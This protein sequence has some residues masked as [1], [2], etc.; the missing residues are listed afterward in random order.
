MADK[1]IRV[2]W[3][4]ELVDKTFL[5]ACIQELTSNGREGSGLKESSWAVVAEKLKTDH[6][7]IVDKKQMKNRYDYL[8]AKYAVWLKLK[9]KT[10]NIYNPVTNSFNMTNEEWEAEAKLNKY[11]D[12]L[13]NAPLPCPELCTQ[14]FDGATSTSVHSWGPSSTLPH[15]NETFSTHDFEDTEMDEPAPHADTPSST[16]PQPTSEESSGRTKNKG[17]KRN[18]P[19]ET[20]L[21]DELKEVGKEIIK[22]AQAFTEA[23]NLDK[24]MDA[25]MAKLTSLEWGEYDPKSTTAL[26]LFAESSGHNERFQAVKE[27]FHHPTQTIHQCFHE[28][29][30]AMM[31]FSREII[32][33][34]SSNSTRN[35][36][37][38]HRRLMQIFPG[39]IGA[40]DGTLVHAVVPVDQQTRYRGR[41]KVECYQ[42]VIGICNFDMIFTFVWAGCEGIA[43]DSKVL[44]EVAF[45]PTSGFPFPPPDKYYLCDAAYT[46]TRGFMAPYR[47]TRYWLADFQRNRALTKEEMFNHAHAQL[48]NYIER[49]YGVLKAR[50]PILKQ[51]DPYPFPVQKNIV[52]SCVAVHNFIRKYDI[53]DELFTNFEQNTMVSHNVGGGGNEGQNI[54]GIEWGSEAVNYMTNL[55]DQIAN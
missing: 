20:T 27:R 45:N 16:V 11:V 14:L 49:A 42:N 34:T 39:A 7:F 37:E 25:C 52:I 26:M 21:D 6:N 23:N 40:L 17:G 24:E 18:G 22:A 13:R 32:V 54:E 41:G 43:H 19:K 35:T 30:R 55:R 2:S 4:S 10:G 12:K 29:L 15:P 48:R 47:N 44:K 28:V 3:K 33:P 51:M 1:R 50:F 53:E 9:N 36:S 8:K 46:N 38:R 31:C 5:E